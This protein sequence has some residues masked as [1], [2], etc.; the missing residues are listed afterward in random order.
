MPDPKAFVVDYTQEFEMISRYMR[1]HRYINPAGDIEFIS[2]ISFWEQDHGFAPGTILLQ[3]N[4]MNLVAVAKG[5]IRFKLETKPSPKHTF[6][7]PKC[8]PS[9]V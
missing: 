5:V 9:E 1:A 3:D 7:T 2:G 8:I 4:G 6:F